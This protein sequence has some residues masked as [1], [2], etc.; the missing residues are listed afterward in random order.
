MRSW[1]F[2]IRRIQTSDSS[3]G[4]I[5]VI[6][7]GEQWKQSAELRP[8]VEDLIGAGAIIAKLGGNKSL[9]AMTAEAAFQS[10]RDQLSS[11]LPRT[12]SG[13][14]LL[15]KGYGDDVEF[16]ASLNVSDAVPILHEK[17]FTRWT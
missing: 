15:E 14:E 2:S 3:G 13:K 8:A 7:S 17:A 6:A 16:A 4:F 9:E 10:V 12:C 1:E 11:S 5:S